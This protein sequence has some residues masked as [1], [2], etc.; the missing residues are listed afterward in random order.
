M[1]SGHELG[2]TVNTIISALGSRDRRIAANLKPTWPREQD[3]VC[4]E[5]KR[6]GWGDAQL[7]K[8]LHQKHEVPRVCAW[9]FTVGKAQIKVS[10]RYPGC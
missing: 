4:K 6:L 5:S 1:L 9:N 10:V 2:A 3:P 8:G 7:A